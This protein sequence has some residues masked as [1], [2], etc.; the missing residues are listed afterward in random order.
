MIVQWAAFA[1]FFIAALIHMGFFVYEWFYLKADPAVKIW[2][3]NQA[4]YN[5]CYAI[6][7]FVGLY[8][9]L[10]LEVKTAGVVISLFGFFMIVAG[11]TL[12]FTVPKLRKAALVQAVPPLLGFVF[13][14]L[15][16]LHRL[17]K[18]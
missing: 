9:V 3:K 11:A 1:L 6:G 7:T 12:W 8:Y 16:I 14:A 2:A 15:H 10:K 5:L 13:L 4:V 17:G 18:L